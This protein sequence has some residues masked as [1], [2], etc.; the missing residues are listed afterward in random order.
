MMRRLMHEQAAAVALIAVPSAEVVGAMLRVQQPFEVNG[1]YFA[2]RAVANQL[3]NLGMMRRI[4]V[5]ERYPQIAACPLNRIENFLAFLLVD[6][7]R[8]LG[9]DIA[10]KLHRTNDISDG[11]CGRSSS[12]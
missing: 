2:D 9:D 11:A 10:A 5:V 4:A 3:A 1:V 6:R 12:R 8:L 7:H